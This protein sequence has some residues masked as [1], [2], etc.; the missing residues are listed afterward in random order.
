MLGLPEAG[1]PLSLLEVT[2]VETWGWGVD[3]MLPP[4]DWKELHV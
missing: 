2:V 1:I 4:H 3:R